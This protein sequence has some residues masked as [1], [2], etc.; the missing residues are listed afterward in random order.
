MGVTSSATTGALIPTA[1]LM[2]DGRTPEEAAQNLMDKMRVAG[3]VVKFCYGSSYMMNQTLP[4][5]YETNIVAGGTIER[6]SIE[7][8]ISP[9]GLVYWRARFGGLLCA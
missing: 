7:R 5:Y 8:M 3:I 4:T 1:D 6:A 2:A 9:S